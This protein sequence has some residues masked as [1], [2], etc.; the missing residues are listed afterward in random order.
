MSGIQVHSNSFGR[1]PSVSQLLPCIKYARRVLNVKLRLA[2]RRQ[3]IQIIL[4]KTLMALHDRLKLRQMRKRQLIQIVL[5]N[6]LVLDDRLKIPQMRG[7][8]LIQIVF[9][10]IWIEAI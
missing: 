6:L 7:G 5:D 1:L 2:R 3:L 8:Q 9:E 4:K 10:N